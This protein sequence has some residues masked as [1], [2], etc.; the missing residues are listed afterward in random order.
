MTISDQHYPHS[1]EIEYSNRDLSHVQDLELLDSSELPEIPPVNTA[2]P[3][4]LFGDV[5]QV[6]EFFHLFGEHVDV[7]EDFPEGVTI[8]RYKGVSH[9]GWC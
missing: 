7:Q 4:S 5:I 2:L 1:E 8:G 9:I 3:V 6:V